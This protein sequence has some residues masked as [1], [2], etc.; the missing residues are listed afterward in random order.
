MQVVD[1]RD[2]GS[3]EIIATQSVNVSRRMVI[4][5]SV[6][7][8]HANIESMIKIFS[9]VGCPECEGDVNGD[10]AVDVNDISYVLLR[11]GDEGGNGDANGDGAVDV[12]DISS[13]LF[14]LGDDCP[15]IT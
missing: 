5:G 13:V 9:L 4:D 14:R 10:G 15:P 1:I 11:L 12:N 7:Y 8:G 2:P 3:M 6:L